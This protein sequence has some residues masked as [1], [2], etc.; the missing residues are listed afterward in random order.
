MGQVLVIIDKYLMYLF[1]VIRSFFIPFSRVKKNSFFLCWVAAHKGPHQ[2]T[3][4]SIF[5]SKALKDG[6]STHEWAPFHELSNP[7]I[8]K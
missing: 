4:A 7:D 3:S 2:S 1:I 5:C 8:M 6:P